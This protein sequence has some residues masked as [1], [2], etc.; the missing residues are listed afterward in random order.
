MYSLSIKIGSALWYFQYLK[1]IDIGKYK[2]K[3]AYMLYIAI[4][5]LFKS[6]FCHTLKICNQS[7]SKNHVNQLV[8]NTCIC[9]NVHVYL[10]IW[11]V[12]FESAIKIS[13]LDK[14]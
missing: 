7:Y 1:P 9:T 11:K 2:N 14:S 8:L 12:S 13:F 3:I 5:I 6:T 10:N 4:A